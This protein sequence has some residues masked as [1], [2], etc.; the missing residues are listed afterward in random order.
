MPTSTRWPFIFADPWSMIY[1]RP[2]ATLQTL[3]LSYLICFLSSPVLPTRFS[4]RRVR[5]S[6]GWV[7]RIT[8]KNFTWSCNWMTTNKKEKNKIEMLGQKNERCTVEKFWIVCFIL[9]VFVR[10]SLRVWKFNGSEYSWKSIIIII[11]LCKIAWSLSYNIT[12]III[13]L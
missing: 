6:S 13:I 12:I 11:Y 8:K 5:A 4:V 9:S 1:R 3:E 10:I 2:P 7:G